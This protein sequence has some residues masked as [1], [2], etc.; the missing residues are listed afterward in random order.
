[1][2]GAWMIDLTTLIPLIVVVSLVY[3]GTRNEQM[4]PILRHA[5]RLALTI[6]VFMAGVFGLLTAMSHWL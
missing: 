6:M 1:M 3:A 5:R 2:N 4:Q